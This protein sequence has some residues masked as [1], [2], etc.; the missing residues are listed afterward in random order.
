MEII[1][2]Q[3]DDKLLTITIEYPRLDTKTQKLI[4]KI[5]TLNLSEKHKRLFKGGS[6]VLKNMIKRTLILAAIIIFTVFSISLLSVGMTPEILLVFEILILSFFVTVIQQFVKQ[7]AGANFLVNI[8]MEYVSVFV[9]LYGYFVQWF[10][11]ANWWMAFVC[12]THI[13]PGLLP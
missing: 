2:R 12:G 4:Q 5:R 11:K 3:T 9:F 10:F 7:A 6:M 8:L 13:Y 1:T